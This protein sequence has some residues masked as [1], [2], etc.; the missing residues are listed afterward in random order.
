LI[1]SGGGVIS[2]TVEGLVNDACGPEIVEQDGEL[3]AT[4]T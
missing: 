2:G 1:Q 4:A 3:A